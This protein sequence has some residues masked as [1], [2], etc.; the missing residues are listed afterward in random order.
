MWD[1]NRRRSGG[2]V[3]AA[4][5]T[6]VVSGWQ[7]SA[8]NNGVFQAGDIP[9]NEPAFSAT[10]TRLIGILDDLDEY[11]RPKKRLPECPKCDEDELGVIHPGLI[12]CYRCGWNLRSKLKETV[13]A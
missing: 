12:M 9:M 4:R 6:V 10:V 2:D 7:L 13:N 5:V 1:E 11:D 8:V 3:H